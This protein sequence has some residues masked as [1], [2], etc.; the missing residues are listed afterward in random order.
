M[1]VFAEST[2]T[3]PV[4]TVKPDQVVEYLKSIYPGMLNAGINIIIILILLLIGHKLIRMLMKIIIKGMQKV[5]LE[6]GAKSFLL[7]IIQTSL[8]IVLV[9]IL[10]ERLGVSSASI[11][12]MLGSA[13]LAIGLALQGSLSNLAGGVLILF[14]KPFVVGD[15]IISPEAE[16][17]VKEIGMIYTTLTTVDNKKVTIPNGSLSNGVITNV[18]AMKERRLDIQVDISYESDIQRAKGIMRNLIEENPMIL[19]D[20]PVEIY[21]DRFTEFSVCIGTK[22]WCATSDYWNLRYEILEQIK[23][24]FAKEDIIMAYHHL[25]IRMKRQ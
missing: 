13:G 7:S 24:R 5:G 19:R 16:G 18:T 1:E 22:M 11:V 21:V 20:Y 2:L 12:A 9:F 10:A 23:E 17:V 8:Y 15:Y 6:E 4:E 14:I 25:D 3:D